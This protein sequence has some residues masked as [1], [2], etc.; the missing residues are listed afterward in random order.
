MVNDAH[1]STRGGRFLLTAA[2][3]VVVVAGMRA[4]ATIL[5][6]FLLAIFVAT[7][8]A[9]ALYWMRK[10]RV[11]SGVAILVILLGVVLVV[12]FFGTM[13]GTSLAGFTRATPQF[14]L[15]LTELTGQF[16]VWLD[17][18]GIEF[19]EEQL[20]EVLNPGRALSLVGSL[21]LGLRGALTNSFM[22]L[23]TV[24][25]IL[26]EASGFPAKLRAA[27][28]DER[29]SMD[30]LKT[31]TES[32]N[33]YLGIKTAFSAMT[34][35]VVWT[36]LHILGVEYAVLCGLIAFLLNYIPNIGS[37]IASIPAVL[38]ALVQLG[39]GSALLTGMGYL[40]VNLLFG[41][42]LEPRFMGKGLGLSTLVV[43]LS[44]VFWGWVLG[45]VGM[46]LSAPLTM[47][48]KIALEANEDTRWI[49]VLM[50]GEPAD[51][52]GLS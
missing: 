29:V 10:K 23:L 6:P 7:I 26:M 11:P 43:F 45:P 16:T 46:L 15:R 44:L 19:P 42:F 18:R 52:P 3:F 21:L 41:S 1:N 47:I 17:A 34:G 5:I 35:F 20:N 27:F 4:A 30:R 25:F 36:W 37:I 14:Q 28:G 12:S 31:I 2:C 8:S 9:P 13:L 48:V 50:G 22:I 51:N 24:V 49:A 33:R 32:I 38:L 39:V 40:A